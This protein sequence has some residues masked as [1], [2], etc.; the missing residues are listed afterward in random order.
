MD[1]P[2][3]RNLSGVYI[4]VKRGDGWE[5]VDFTDLTVEERENYLSKQEPQALIEMCRHLANAVGRI[6]DEMDIEMVF[7]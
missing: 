6:S 1:Y 5:S 3:K 2:I 4:R 7:E